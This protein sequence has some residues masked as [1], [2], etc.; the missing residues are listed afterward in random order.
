MCENGY[1]KLIDFGVACL[2]EE[3]QLGKTLC[4][5]PEYMAPEMISQNRSYEKTVDWW[6]FCWVR[7]GM[8]HDGGDDWC[9]A[10][11]MASWLADGGHEAAAAAGT[12]RGR[13][14]LHDATHQPRGGTEV[15]WTRGWKKGATTTSAGFIFSL[16]QFARAKN[17]VLLFFSLLFAL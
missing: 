17:C 5:T 13:T 14:Q 6:W 16:I 8:S 11:V 10:A 9:M 15:G 7:V 2:L 12:M 4:G 1:L 3:G